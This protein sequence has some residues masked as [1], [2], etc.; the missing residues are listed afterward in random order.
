MICVKKYWTVIGETTLECRKLTHD[1]LSL[2]CA[3]LL[4]EGNLGFSQLPDG[5]KCT[6]ISS[7]G[8]DLF[9][10]LHKFLAPCRRKHPYISNATEK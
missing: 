4:C 10:P 9:R 6:C 1:I 3:I 7:P 5:R 2:G 8:L